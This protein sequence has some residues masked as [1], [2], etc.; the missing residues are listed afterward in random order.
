M[1]SGVFRGLQENCTS[2]LSL[3]AN[4]SYIEQSQGSLNSVMR[5][6]GQVLID[7]FRIMCILTGG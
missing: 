2:R 4:E 1:G 6:L 7:R 5:D 3:P